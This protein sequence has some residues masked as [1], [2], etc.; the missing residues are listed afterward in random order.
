MKLIIDCREE[1]LYSKCWLINNGFEASHVEIEKKSLPLGDALIE[2]EEGR[3]VW[4]VERKTLSDLLASIKDGRYE[5]QS[6]R[7]QNDVEHPR[8]NVIYIIEGMMSQLLRPEHKRVVL[9]TIASLS[10]FKGFSVFRTCNV[11]ETAELL[12]YISDKIDRKFQK[13][14]LPYV[15]SWDSTNKESCGEGIQLP[16]SPDSNSNSN[17]IQIPSYTTVVKK[18]KKENITD[19]NIGEIIL[20]Q[21]PGI[22]S[23][24]AISIMSV[25]GKSI[26]TL[27]EYLENDISKIENIMIGSE[28]KK[29]KISK[30]I[31][32][33]LQLFLLK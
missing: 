16:H 28:T 30:S 19:E 26:K 21:L 14:F 24:T 22:S 6:Y 10:F 32:E 23:V 27:I 1:D 3:S 9:S 8:H 18:V 11:H 25:C 13:G 29:R 20:S 33:K 2:T 17:S 15:Y 31:V 5:E 12:V 4:I 7:L